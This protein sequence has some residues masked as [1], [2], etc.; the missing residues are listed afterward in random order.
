M[1]V[2]LVEDDSLLRGS[3]SV[4]LGGERGF[5]VVGAFGSAEEALAG[6]AQGNP[7]VML[8][9]I[10]LPGMNGIELIREVK[11]HHPEVELMAFTIL[12]DRDTVF[13]AIKAGAS[14]YLLKGSPPRE[15]VESLHTLYQGGAPMTPRIAK[16][17]LLEMRGEGSDETEGL[18]V[19]ERDILAQIQKGMSY[20]EIG[21]QFYISPHTVHSHIKRIYEKLQAR[22]RKEALLKARRQGIL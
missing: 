2:A 4:L 8:V 16:K 11:R 5:E 6:L 22:G 20:R 21:E 12:E 14:G 15:V 19:R 7:E 17:V 1:R 9:D 10:D 13:A 3:V 18:S